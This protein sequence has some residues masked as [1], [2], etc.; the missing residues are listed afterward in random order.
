MKWTVPVLLI[1]ARDSVPV[2]VISPVRFLNHLPGSS[3]ISNEAKFLFGD[4]PGML[5][6][7]TF[8]SPDI[9]LKVP[10]MPDSMCAKT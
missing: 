1:T 7:L 9:T 3:L 10:V 4:A 8:Q 6:I 5:D 2:F